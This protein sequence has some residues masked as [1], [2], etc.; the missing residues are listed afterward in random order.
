MDDSVITCYEDT[1]AKSNDETTIQANFNE[2]KHKLQNTTFLY[3]AH[4]FI[5]H[6]LHY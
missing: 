2:K 6:Q 1:E 3:F 5:N 4:L